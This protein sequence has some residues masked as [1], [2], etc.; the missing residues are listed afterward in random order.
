MICSNKVR[1]ICYAPGAAFICAIS[2][3]P[4]PRFNPAT[5]AAASSRAALSSAM[6]WNSGISFPEP[7]TRL[8]G[9]ASTT[10]HSIEEGG[11]T[12]H[13]K[14]SAVRSSQSID[15]HEASKLSD[16]ESQVLDQNQAVHTLPPLIRGFPRRGRG[17]D[18]AD[19]SQ[20][21]AK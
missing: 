8:V 20:A 5:A 2:M 3:T 19:P 17:P 16:D 11:S 9:R 1:E 13:E 4:Q 12:L 10:R 21:S 15:Y 6:R 7:S 14:A 18:D